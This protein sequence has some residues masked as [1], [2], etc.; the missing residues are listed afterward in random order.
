MDFK[1][2]VN[3]SATLAAALGIWCTLHKAYCFIEPGSLQTAGHIDLQPL[4]YLLEAPVRSLSLAD[5][6]KQVFYAVDSL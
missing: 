5:D 6:N 3:L 4:N 2:R 1:Y